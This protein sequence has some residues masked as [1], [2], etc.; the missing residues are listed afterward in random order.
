[1]HSLLIGRVPPGV[2][3]KLRRHQ[4]FAWRTRRDNRPGLIREVF[5][6]A[7]RTEVTE[8]LLLTSLSV[9]WPVGQL[10]VQ[11]NHA[12]SRQTDTLH[13]FKMPICLFEQ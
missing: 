8:Q 4:V 9:P 2:L 1:M 7:H 10:L 11:I 5:G 13:L 12:L 6:Y 3:R